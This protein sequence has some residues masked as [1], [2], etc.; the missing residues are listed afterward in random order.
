M[1]NYP[2]AGPRGKKLDRIQSLP[3]SG[4]SANRVS[5]WEGCGVLRW[6]TI[7]QGN[8]WGLT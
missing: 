1:D 6:D 8:L 2:V 4:G 7:G 3:W 5:P